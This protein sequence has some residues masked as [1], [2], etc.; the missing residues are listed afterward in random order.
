MFPPAYP[1]QPIETIYPNVHL[2]RGSIRMG[3]GMRLNRNMVI[4]QQGDELTLINPVR[5]D[6]EGLKQ[7][8][9]L[10][11]VKHIIRLGDFHGL[12]DP[13]Y[14]DRY[15]CDFWA[16]ANQDTYKVPV[17]TQLITEDSQVPVEG[18]EFFL[19]STAKYPEAAIHIQ[20]HK[21]L[22][23][24]DAVQYY[25]DW[26]FTSGFTKFAFKLLGFKPGMN[27]GPPWL[28]RVTPKGESMK[29]DFA[30]LTEL[31]FDALVAAHGSLIR[32]GAKTL[33]Q[34]QMALK[35]S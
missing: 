26:L 1:H 3:P 8:D 34:E 33:L 31:D 28:K 23:T 22:I 24:T 14:L 12:D 5:L 10:G 25:D 18:A 11:Q 15:Q 29:G 32:Q 16:Q 9:A 4:L 19:F 13:F 21:L 35:L 6:E 27:I 17:P 7:L 2:V 30:Q 20:E